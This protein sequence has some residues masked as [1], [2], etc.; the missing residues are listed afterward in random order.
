MTDLDLTAL[1][2]AAT[3]RPWNVQ[4]TTAC[5]DVIQGGDRT[6]DSRYIAMMGVDYDPNDGESFPPHHDAD[7]AL[8][9]AAV[10][11][12]ERLLEIER[13]AREFRAWMKRANVLI[14]AADDLFTAMDGLDCPSFV[15]QIV[16]THNTRHADLGVE[17]GSGGAVDPA[18]D[19]ARPTG[20]TEGT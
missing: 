10:N 19:A 6:T 17:Y 4:N 8:I 14:T 7:A 13:A 3:P 15:Q 1:L 18:P 2:D 5:Y 20:Q 9:V 16:R 12:Y 11:A